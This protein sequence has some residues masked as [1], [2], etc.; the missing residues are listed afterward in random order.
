MNSP[1]RIGF[2]DL[3]LVFIESISLYTGWTRFATFE[4]Q[5]VQHQSFMINISIMS[6]TISI[7]SQKEG[8]GKTTIA[9]NIATSL[10][11]FEKKHY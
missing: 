4:K 10:A 1:Y 3:Q 8:T 9:V 11:L 2:I 6:K 7:I 5:P